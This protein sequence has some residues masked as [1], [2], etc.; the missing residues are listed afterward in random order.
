LAKDAIDH[1]KNAQQKRAFNRLLASSKIGIKRIKQETNNS[2][3]KDQKCQDIPN[4][5]CYATLH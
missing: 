2:S 1:S 3:C 5:E 4:I